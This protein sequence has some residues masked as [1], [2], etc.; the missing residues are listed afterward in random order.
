MNSRSVARRRSHQCFS[1]TNTNAHDLEAIAALRQPTVKFEII[2]LVIVLTR[3]PGTGGYGSACARRATSGAP[4]PAHHNLAARLREY[5]E[6]AGPGRRDRSI[7]RRGPFFLGRSRDAA[8][9][10]ISPNISP[11]ISPLCPMCPQDALGQHSR[12]KRCTSDTRAC[13]GAAASG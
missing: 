11:N 3:I 9:A 5:I 12:P 2:N 7:Q 10:D 13:E 1:R 6:G 4:R 8:A